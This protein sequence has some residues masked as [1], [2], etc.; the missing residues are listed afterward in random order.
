MRCTF[1][2]ERNEQRNVYHKRNPS[3]QT[4]SSRGE[5][6]TSFTRVAADG[7]FQEVSSNVTPVVERLVS[8][9]LEPA[10]L[11]FS[12]D[13]HTSI[14]PKKE[15]PKEFEFQLKILIFSNSYYILSYS[16][17][18]VTTCATG[19]VL[20]RYADYDPEDVT[21][22]YDVI[23]FGGDIDNDRLWDFL[24]KYRNMHQLWLLNTDLN[25]ITTKHIIPPMT[26]STTAFNISLTYHSKSEISVPYGYC[27]RRTNNT[28]Q[29][30][31]TL[32][33]NYL[34][35]HPK[36]VAWYSG[37]CHNVSWNR[38]RFVSDLSRSIPIDL[39]GTCGNLSCGGPTL[40]SKYRRGSAYC[41]SLSEYKFVLA[42]EES[43][44]SEYITDN[45]WNVLALYNGIPVVVGPSKDQYERL[46]PPNSFI[47]A[48][49]FDST[50]ELAA[51]MRKVASDARIYNS[52]FKWKQ[53]WSVG[54][55]SAKNRL[56]PA[57]NVQCSL[58]EY[59][60]GRTVNSTKPIP[61]T[62]QVDPYGP[63]WIGSCTSCEEHSM[64]EKYR[65]VDTDGHFAGVR[66]DP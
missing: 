54:M 9:K 55:N 29:V 38:Q 30:N 49:D 19:K 52:F 39:Y 64:L 59:I 47:F 6:N 56:L 60:Q 32:S 28:S 34:E 41:R 50:S 23:V 2:P 48:G 16:H 18:R 26:S 61:I 40:L 31:E 21:S 4:D 13:L 65:L 7:R 14:E 57:G 35:L 33:Q 58:L 62:T 46:A 10:S 17:S 12:D 22:A 51:Y 3:V 20:A 63:Y 15:L 25:P 43:C 53:H 5:Y 45:F 11:N 36:L 37:D 8:N 44:C 27:L 66:S 1:T 24:S 42:L